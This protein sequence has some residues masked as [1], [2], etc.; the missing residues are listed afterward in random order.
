MTIH[1]LRDRSACMLCL[2][3]FGARS[4]VHTYFV[5]LQ[6]LFVQVLQ[7]Y[8]IIGCLHLLCTELYYC[9]HSIVYRLNYYIY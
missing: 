3:L 2:S 1:Q 7:V 9:G 4:V 6:Y 8:D 5:L